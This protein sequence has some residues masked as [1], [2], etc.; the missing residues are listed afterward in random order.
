MQGV[1]AWGYGAQASRI[2]VTSYPREL[3]LV[4]DPDALV[5]RVNLL[6]AAG[7]LSTTTLTTIR[8]A[9]A[10]IRIW[11]DNERKVRVWATIALV[12][13]SPEYLVQKRKT[14]A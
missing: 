9:I 2:A 13:A 4:D 8:N 10:S 14:R 11:G 6:L 1:I 12:M 3:A 7:Q 5:Q